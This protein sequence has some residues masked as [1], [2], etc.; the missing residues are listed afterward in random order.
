VLQPGELEGEV[1]LAPI[2]YVRHVKRQRN[3]GLTRDGGT[4]TSRSQG[5]EAASHPLTI[6]VCADDSRGCNE[7]NDRCELHYD[8]LC[9]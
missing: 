7:G 9:F 2:K 1:L 5:R 6:G 4:A 8:L 3:F